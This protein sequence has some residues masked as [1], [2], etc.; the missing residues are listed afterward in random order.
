LIRDKTVHEPYGN[1]DHILVSH[2][3]IFVIETKNWDGAYACDGDDWTNRYEGDF[4]S[5]DYALEH[6]LSKRV[7][8]NA[9]ILKERIESG[10]SKSIWVQG[11]IVFANF[12]VKLSVTNDST[13]PVV[14][15]TELCKHIKSYGPIDFS[16]EEL[17]T[18]AYFISHL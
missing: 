1:I 8:G 10:L 12:N 4:K 2:H 9:V 14:K 16:S 15:A 5:I 17:Q 6:S 3:A 18:I 7:K 11:L 13:V